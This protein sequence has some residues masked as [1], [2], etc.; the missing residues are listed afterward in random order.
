MSRWYYDRL[1]E[2]DHE[3]ENLRLAHSLEYG[4]IWKLKRAHH[5][6]SMYLFFSYSFPS[7]VLINPTRR[8]FTNLQ[9]YHI[10]ATTTNNNNNNSLK[11]KGKLVSITFYQIKI[12]IL[13]LK[14]RFY[15]SYKIKTIKFN[16][17]ISLYHFFIL[18]SSHD[19]HIVT[20]LTI[21]WLNIIYI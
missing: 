17:N 11:H 21:K 4:P 19:S 9:V 10:T 13:Y 16:L 18:N 2:W 20:F 14:R 12:F 1:V 15:V 8:F 6:P 7:R 5:R 3:G